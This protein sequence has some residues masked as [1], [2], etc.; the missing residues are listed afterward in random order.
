IQNLCNSDSAEFNPLDIRA[1]NPTREDKL[2]YI[3]MMEKGCKNSHA[4][5]NLARLVRSHLRMKK[6]ATELYQ[7]AEET[8]ES[9]DDYR[10]LAYPVLNY[11]K[12]RD[13]AITLYLKA[14]MA[15]KTY[16]N[17]ENLGW[18]VGSLGY[19]EWSERLYS[20]AGDLK[21]QIA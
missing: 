15:A 17:Y 14:E 9:Y 5:W 18:M 16:H 13:R 10:L 7:K 12:D 8:A 19:K 20:K 4:F 3:K 1:K 2:K 21:Q 11:L 6:W